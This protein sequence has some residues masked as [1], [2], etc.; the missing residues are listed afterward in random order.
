M[1]AT[2]WGASS[3]PIGRPVRVLSLSFVGKPLEVIRNLIDAEAAKGVDLVVLPETWRGQKDDTME[4][5]DGPT[6]AAM[7]EL[8]RKHRTYIVSPIDRIDGGRRVNT[9]VLLDR[10]GK[11]V[12]LYDKIYPYWSEFDHKKKVE[13]GS[14]AP[15]Y[16]ERWLDRE[17][18][19]VLRAH[20]PGVSARALA[21]QYGMEE[22]RDYINRSRQEID[23][24][25]GKRL[26]E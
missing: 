4:A 3:G 17:Q 16:Q 10:N 7:S 21:R 14:A 2:I 24:M 23:R 12:S 9:A 19:F 1:A 18:W 6:I 13:P 11:V 25:R 26:A 22:L 8:A 5:L 20:R 15:V